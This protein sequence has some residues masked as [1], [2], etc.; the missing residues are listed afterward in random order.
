[1]FN[2]IVG[3]FCILVAIFLIHTDLDKNAKFILFDTVIGAINLSMGLFLCLDKDNTYIVTITQ[4]D[5]T[6]IEFK[7]KDYDV[8]DTYIKVKQDDGYLYIYEIKDIKVVQKE[9]K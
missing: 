5:G 1:M 6:A 9:D 8:E 2:I 4:K 3:C 7:T